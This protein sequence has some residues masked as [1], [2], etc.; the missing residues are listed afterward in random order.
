MKSNK[1]K[2]NG[3]VIHFPLTAALWRRLIRKSSGD[4]EK[5]KSVAEVM[6]TEMEMR[7]R[8]C[9]ARGCVSPK[10]IDIRML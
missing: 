7:E 3:N 6:C 2:T 4:A 1:N 8:I 9:A 10:I 5:L